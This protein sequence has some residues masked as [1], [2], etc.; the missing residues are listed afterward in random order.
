M[1]EKK[2]KNNKKKPKEIEDLASDILNDIPEDIPLEDIPEDVPDLVE[3]PED[4]EQKYEKIPGQ[5]VEEAKPEPIQFERGLSK[6]TAFVIQKNLREVDQILEQ[7]FGRGR[8]AYFA[9]SENTTTSYVNNQRKRFKCMRVED[10]NGFG[11][12]LWFDLSLL[13]IF[14]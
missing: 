14:G 12:T 13:G 2:P 11:Y 4:V 8:G 10:R 6:A 7:Y 3:S 5:E 1:K 9:S